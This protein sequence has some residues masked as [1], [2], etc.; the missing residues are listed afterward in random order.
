MGNNMSWDKFMTEEIHIDHIIPRAYFYYE[1][2]EDQ[3]FKDCWALSNLRL[4][5][6]KDNLHKQ[7]KMPDGTRARVYR[8]R[9]V[10]LLNEES[11]VAG[12][13]PL[14]F[15]GDAGLAE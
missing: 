9:K 14:V 12:Y 15:Y 1:S 8:D 4:A 10:A 13:E 3:D 2:E 6:A 7:D 5:W 11:S